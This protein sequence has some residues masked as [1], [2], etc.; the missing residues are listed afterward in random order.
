MLAGLPKLAADEIKMVGLE[1]KFSPEEG[2]A[3]TILIRNGS[4]RELQF[5]QFPLAVEDA[6]GD[7]ICQSTFKLENFTVKPYATKPWTFVFPKE[8]ILKS[9]PD[10]SSWKVYPKQ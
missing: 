4:S 7:V 3:A 9:S 1:T 8:L 10:L 5:E 6:A 2:L